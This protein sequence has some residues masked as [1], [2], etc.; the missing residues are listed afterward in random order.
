[1]SLK[2]LGDFG[3]ENVD[4]GTRIRKITGLRDIKKFRK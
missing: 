2:S 3:S 1:M 4:S